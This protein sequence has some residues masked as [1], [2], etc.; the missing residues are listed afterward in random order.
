MILL[1]LINIDF[2]QGSRVVVGVSRSP[3]FGPQ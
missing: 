1:V 3:G 2:F